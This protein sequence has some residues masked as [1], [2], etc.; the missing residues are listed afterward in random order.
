MSLCELTPY[1]DEAAA[2]IHLKF[3]QFWDKRQVGGCEMP[4]ENFFFFNF[5]YYW[6]RIICQISERGQAFLWTVGLDRPRLNTL[7]VGYLKPL[8][9]SSVFL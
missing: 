4:K 3:E 2:A 8:T 6:Y 5:V 9:Q 1:V 7:S